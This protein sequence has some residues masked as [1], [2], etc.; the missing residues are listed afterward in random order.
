MKRFIYFLLILLSITIIFSC[1][2]SQTS[3]KNDIESDNSTMKILAVIPLTGNAALY[4][5]YS[6]IGLNMAT[7]EWNDSNPN[8][9]IEVI[10]EDSKGEAGEAV[11]IIQK[12]ITDDDLLF[13]YTQMSPIALATKNI[14]EGKSIINIALSGSNELLENSK[15]IIRN[16]YDPVSNSEIVA[17]LIKNEMKKSKIGVLYQNDDFGRS[18]AN[19]LEE[20]CQK[21]D[22]DI[23]FNELYS[24]ED[25][26]YRVLIKKVLDDKEIEYIHI[27]GY[28]KSLGVIIKQL[29]QMGYS[30]IIG[31]DGGTNYPNVI[32]AAGEAIDGVYYLDFDFDVEKQNDVLQNEFM[33]LYNEVKSD[34]DPKTPSDV[35]TIT[36]KATQ[37]FL[38]SYKSSNYNKNADSLLKIINNYSSEDL[39]GKVYVDKR[40]I[41]YKQRFKKIDYKK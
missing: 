6:Q 34:S 25:L 39:L 23:L 16:Y 31:S 8:K 41:F 5:S 14:T 27:V 4:G 12:S 29:R 22:I 38:S 13:V 2:N 15:Y 3:S 35:T 1:N 21:K 11:S 36:Y 9:K 18:V 10:I 26:D 37:I 7:K 28:G 33:K 32:E 20:E 19:K 17:N 40:N 24:T 30:G